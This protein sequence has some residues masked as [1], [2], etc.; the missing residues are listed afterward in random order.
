LKLHRSDPRCL[1]TMLQLATPV[2]FQLE[3]QQ[4]LSDD[5]ELQSLTPKVL[6]ALFQNWYEKGDRLGL[7]ESLREHPG[8][9]N[10]A[11]RQL[12]RIYAEYRDYRQAYETVMRHIT[13]PAL[14]QP[15]PD[16]TIESLATRFRAEGRNVD[17]GLMLAQA[18]AQQDKV[19]DALAILT[20]LSA[21][22]SAPR[23]IHFLEAQL[24]ARKGDWQ[25]AWQALSQ[26]IND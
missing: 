26:F 20:T 24:Q 7:A 5:P 22:P 21:V 6:N 17:A 9:E 25:K 8:W 13:P 23:A 16:D 15:E 2:E 3:L 11:W 1:T 12:A 19:D 18:E 14:P 10:I 4:L